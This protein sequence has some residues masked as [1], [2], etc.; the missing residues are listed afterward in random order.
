MTK[1]NP[2]KCYTKRHY[3][4]RRTLQVNGEESKLWKKLQ[5]IVKKL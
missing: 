3:S 2:E 1:L 5:T 4:N